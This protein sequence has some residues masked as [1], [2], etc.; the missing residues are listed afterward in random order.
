MGVDVPDREEKAHGDDGAVGSMPLRL[1]GSLTPALV[2]VD[3][4]DAAILPRDVDRVPE[5]EHELDD[6]RHGEAKKHEIDDR[7]EHRAAGEEANQRAR[8]YSRFSF[9]K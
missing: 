5:E 8:W 9:Q 3:R 4:K 2:A 6:V 7:D 1:P